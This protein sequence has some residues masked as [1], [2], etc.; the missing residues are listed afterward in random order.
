M[1]FYRI[2]VLLARVSFK[3]PLLGTRVHYDETQVAVTGLEG[4]R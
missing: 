1:M 3:L 2:I 4:D